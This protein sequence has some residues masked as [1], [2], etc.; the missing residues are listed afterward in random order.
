MQLAKR[1]AA[2]GSPVCRKPHQKYDGRK[3]IAR[4]G[5]IDQSRRV[6]G[7]AIACR[8]AVCTVQ[9]SAPRVTTNTLASAAHSCTMRFIVADVFDADDD[10]IGARQ[11]LGGLAP[12]RSD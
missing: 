6:G 9:P 1:A 5:R 12:T 2:I 11:H 3:N 7:T 4:A 10:G 8:L